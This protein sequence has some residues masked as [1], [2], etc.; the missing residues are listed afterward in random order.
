MSI[1]SGVLLLLT[2]NTNILDPHAFAAFDELPAALFDRA[3]AVFDDESRP[4]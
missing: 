1:K 4:W 2:E 3:F